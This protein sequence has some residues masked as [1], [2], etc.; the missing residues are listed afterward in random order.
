MLLAF[1]VY[2]FNLVIIHKKKKKKVPSSPRS[3]NLRGAASTWRP[4]FVL[5]SDLR[6]LQAA[7]LQGTDQTPHVAAVGPG[8][9]IRL[10]A[11]VSLLLRGCNKED[12]DNGGGRRDPAG[13]F[14]DLKLRL[15]LVLNHTQRLHPRPACPHG[16]EPRAHRAK[17]PGPS[18]PG[19]GVEAGPPRA[20]L[21]ARV[22]R[23]LPA[24]PAGGG[25]RPREEEAERRP[26]PSP[27]LPAGSAGSYLGAGPGL[28][29]PAA[30]WA[31]LRETRPPPASASASASACPRRL[32]RAGERA[33]PARQGRPARPWPGVRRARPR[34]G[35]APWLVPIPHW[36]LAPAC[37]S[38]C[39]PGWRCP[40]LPRAAGCVLPAAPGPGQVP[41]GCVVQ[42]LGGW[43]LWQVGWREA[44]R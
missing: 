14:K 33:A 16:H 26:P 3:K 24:S 39:R 34:P 40:S 36:A 30:A 20:G 23:A 38:P 6:A 42:R 5:K 25:P 22:A 11:R 18:R 44:G 21:V 9:T 31:R 32:L 28:L 27:P 2:R 1:S 43:Q 41:L 10:P 37:A 7:R 13:R 4:L 19:R 35:V 8:A 15:W 12:R 17:R 29:Q